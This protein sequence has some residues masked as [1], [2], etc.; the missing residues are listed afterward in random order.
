M[1]DSDFAKPMRGP[2]YLKELIKDMLAGEICKM[3]TIIPAKVLL[4]NHLNSTVSV[5]PL[6][7]TKW[8]R[9]SLR[10][11]ANMPLQEEVPIIF[12]T[13]Q[14]GGCRLTMPI[15]EGDVGLL[16]TSDRRTEIYRGTDGTQPTD[17]GSRAAMG[18]EGRVNII[19]FLPEIFT[20]SAN[21][22][23]S[24]DDLELYYNDSYLRITQNNNIHLN[25]GKA[26]FAQYNDGQILLQTGS[27]S[28]SLEPDNSV[29]VT[30]GSGT[31]KLGSDGTIDLNGVK[32]APDG[33]I[34]AP[35]EIK[36]PKV[37]AGSSI[38]KGGKEMP[39]DEHVHGAGSYKVGSENVTGTSGNV[40]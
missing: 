38:T 31:F 33:T 8:E 26:H 13:A 19:G 28:C 7:R 20:A 32:I 16:I 6:I 10:G 39:D 37:S 9:Y 14:R 40:N 25:N 15:K 3:R 12:P 29:T 36:V 18:Y 23:F 4:V 2:S 5:E 35:T 17:S 11:E 22:S 34:T 27:V 1:F 21:Q 24:S 30:N